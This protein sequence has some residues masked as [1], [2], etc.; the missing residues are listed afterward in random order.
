VPRP[1]R[2]LLLFG[3]LAAGAYGAHRR[4]VRTA[5]SIE[6][7]TPASDPTEPVDEPLP[8][9][10]AASPPWV[11][12]VPTGPEAIVVATME[13]TPVPAPRR[14]DQN[15]TVTVGFEP[16]GAEV[17]NVVAKPVEL[18]AG[19]RLSGL[20]IASLAALAGVGAILLGSWAFVSSVLSD[21]EP[22]AAGAQSQRVIALLSKPSTLRVPVDG[23]AGRIIL[24]VGSAGR[25]Y[26]VLDDLGAAPAG[27]SYQAWVG[28]PAAKS[29]AS[30][31]VFSGTELL[32]P[33]S[34]AIRSG[35]AV[36]ITIERAGGAP[37]PS[38]TP[39]LVAQPSL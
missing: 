3:A 30:A 6:L 19:T 18:P 25:G 26:L 2:W 38:K 28:L 29:P 34:V 24:A 36:A 12:V 5:P 21:D 10:E 17:T 1:P 15:G 11:E 32:V 39:K 20:T 9:H 31:A 7:E 33:L 23:S 37:A 22:T 35:V 14:L 8:A 16:L 4:R 27:K 13:V